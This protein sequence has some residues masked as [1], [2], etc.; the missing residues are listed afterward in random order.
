[1]KLNFIILLSDFD[2]RI[3]LLI[4]IIENWKDENSSKV[5]IDVFPYI[6]LFI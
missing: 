1:M 5:N 2:E 3:H 4:W 6:N